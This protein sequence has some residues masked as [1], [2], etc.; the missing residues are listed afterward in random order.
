[1]ASLEAKFLTIIIRRIYANERLVELG[2]RTPEEAEKTAT[3]AA[4]QIDKIFQRFKHV[5]RS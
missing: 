1:M 3:E 5:H 4:E 2:S